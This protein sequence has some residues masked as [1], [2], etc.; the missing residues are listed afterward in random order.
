MNS[1]SD[2]NSDPCDMKESLSI[3]N[4]TDVTP[5]MRGIIA[6]IH[7]SWNWSV[8]EHKKYAKIESKK[9]SK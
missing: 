6:Y 5:F 4:I 7:D 9:K 2:V 1:E 8:A 3:C